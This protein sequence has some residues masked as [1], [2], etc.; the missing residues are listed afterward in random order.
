MNL[1]QNQNGMHVYAV[2]ALC[3]FAISLYEL[4]FRN[5]FTRLL[6]RVTLRLSEAQIFMLKYLNKLKCPN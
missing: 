6:S 2:F 3:K 5:M 1:M 4:T